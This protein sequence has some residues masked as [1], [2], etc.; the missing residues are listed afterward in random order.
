LLTGVWITGLEH[1][2]FYEGA[3]NYAEAIE[4]RATLDGETWFSTV[5]RA[6]KALQS[7]P[8]ITD[9]MA[10]KVEIIGQKSLCEGEYGHGGFSSH[11]V[12]AR[13]FLSIRPIKVLRPVDQ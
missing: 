12:F 5:G 4:A 10:F 7:L 8:L 9:G 6:Y 13:H 11:E 3:N 2:A 1:S